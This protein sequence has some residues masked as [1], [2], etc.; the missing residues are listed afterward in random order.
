MR[1]LRTGSAS[2][3]LLGAFAHAQTN[4]PAAP[5][6]E[7]VQVR[8]STADL[9]RQST[10]TAIVIN[11]DELL[12][13]GDGSLADVLKR[14]PG[15]TID[16]TPGKP[17]ATRMRGMGSGYASIMI[18]GVPAP[19][20]FS[21]ES[22]S[23][24]LI[25]RIE[26][27]RATTAETSSQAVAGSINVVLRKAGAGQDEFKAGS[28]MLAG[29]AAPT[30]TAQHAGRTGTL[31]Y[32]VS[33]TLRRNDNPISAVDTETGEQIG[34]RPA[35]LRRTAWLDH[36]VEDMLE[37]APRLSWQPGAID[38]LSLQAYLRKRHIDNAK[39]ERETTV[40]GSPTAF[41]R[42]ITTYETRP[43][44]AYGELGWTRRLQ[45]GARLETR[46]SGYATRREAGF[47]YRGM[48]A[49]E[50]LLETHRVASGPREHEW[51]FKGN[52]RRPFGEG[53]ALAVGWEL[54]RKQRDEYRREHQFTLEG[55]ELL[56]SDES[57]RATVG[58]SA[59]F[60]QDEWDISPAWSAYV[61]LRREDLHTTG[62]GNAAAPVD[63][64]SGV[65]SPIAQALYKLETDGDGRR[66]QVRLAVGRTYKAPDIIQ[67]MPRRYTV[68]NNNSATNP[69]QQGNPNLKP[70]L[71][72]GI[73]LAW[74]R[75]LDKNSM[76]SVSAFHKRIRDVTLSRIYQSG[77]VWV[78]TPD[79]LGGA[80][81]RGVEFEGKTTR[82]ALAARV[83]LARN[84]SRLDAVPGPDNRID[85]QPAWSGNLGADYALAS[86]T[87]DAGGTL[88]YRGRYASR[89]SAVQASAGGVKRQ[90]DL[91]AV[92]KRGR[93]GKLR[94]SVSDLLHQDYVE[95][96]IYTGSGYLARTTVYRIHPTWRVVWEQAL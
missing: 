49:S 55:A 42:A 25:E 87:F 46:L 27:L 53:H 90:L 21:L 14:Q 70:E 91:Y 83:N 16:A 65:W 75:Y 84:W 32:A 96:S 73:D 19:A 85:G 72:L 54:G 59:F 66:D 76:L 69:D 12:R 17:A 78:S 18:N 58:R 80:T 35:L 71:A 1:F 48:D 28:T 10:T 36:Q 56:A 37:L 4:P 13:Q 81:V 34:Q 41:P 67:L 74:E 57:Y 7:Q 64:D 45:G 89:Q 86:G 43:S 31:S 11:R 51:T 68:D 5:Q 60:I 93:T 33:A 9:R 77:G 94:V 79:N 29:Y 38:S 24:D 20:G 92:W 61:G 40:A 47:L 26:I 3:L 82:G 52:W 62:A 50:R 8:A 88:S 15:I 6:I 23:P 63:V 2:A 44:Y 39:A 30:V 95:A 22:I